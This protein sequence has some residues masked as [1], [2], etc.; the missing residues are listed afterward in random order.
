MQIDWKLL[1]LLF[2]NLIIN[3]AISVIAPFYP[4]EAGKRGISSD[5]VGFVFASLP[6]GGFAFSLIFGKYMRFW[7]RK[8]I[9]F[10]GMFLLI[11]GFIM[12][13]LIDLTLNTT[14]FLTISI[15]ARMI[16]GLGLSAYTSVSYAYLPLLYS[17]EALQQKIGYMEASTGIGMLIAPIFGSLLYYAWGYQSPFYVM[18][19]VVLLLSPWLIRALPPDELGSETK[20]KPLSLRKVLSKRKIILT[21]GLSAFVMAG[22][23]F[24]EP[25]F[26]DHL[27]TY[28][29]EVLEIGLI[30]SLG[31]LS[32][33]IFMIVVGMY[34]EKY[35]RRTLM[36]V[37]GVF[38][39]ISFELLGPEWMIGLPKEIWIVCVGMTILGF[40]ATLT[41]LPIIPEFISLCEEIYQNEKIAVGDLSSG[42]F[43]SSYLV[44]GLFGPIM[45]GY[46]TDFFGFPHACSLFAIIFI[47]YLL[48]YIVFGGV[49]EGIA[50]E[51][52]VGEPL[53]QDCA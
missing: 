30:F 1:G 53:L 29:L 32:Y 28:G 45:G 51:K 31:T 21:Y 50:K 36:I 42:M 19:L 13:A 12:F 48:V 18:A 20:S 26:A 38:Y 17:D 46:F 37:G 27:S 39:V 52:T 44:G 34:S 5:I 25:V 16:Q 22:F 8:K 14:I 49:L 47:A 15:I 33:T 11:I 23:S 43:D 3:A 6:L 10:L 4:R 24:I 40:A 7:G 35:K 9:L 41:V 2:L